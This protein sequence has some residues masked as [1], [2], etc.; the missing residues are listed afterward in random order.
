MD[1]HLLRDRAHLAGDGVVVVFATVDKQTGHLATSPEVLSRGFID[2]EEG[3]E[4]IERAKDVLDGALAGENRIADF[5]ET[6]ARVRDAVS[7][8]LYDETR[9]RP[10][11]LTVTVEV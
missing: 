9:R 1:Q 11:V 8:F 7:K 10:M 3:G 2:L 4:L 6:N 5:S